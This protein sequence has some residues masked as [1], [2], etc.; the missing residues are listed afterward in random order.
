MMIGPFAPQLY[1]AFSDSAICMVDLRRLSAVPN[2]GTSPLSTRDLR[3][4]SALGTAFES[5]QQRGW[6][7]YGGAVVT[8]AAL[9][10]AHAFLALL[11]AALPAPTSVD[12]EPDGEL[13]FEWYKSPAW[14]FSV[15]V[16]A[17]PVLSFAGLYGAN[18]A[19]GREQF[20]DK[21][22]AAIVENLQRFAA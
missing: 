4:A 14:V 22:P 15:S 5:A 19:H 17:G 1:A 6:D 9:D 18:V 16:G 21:L 7:D 12:V 8:P 2:S 10:R 3:L 20:V 11:P 13:A